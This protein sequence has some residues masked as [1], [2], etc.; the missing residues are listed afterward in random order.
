LDTFFPGHYSFD[1]RLLFN[2]P[3]VKLEA[4]A[5]ATIPTPG[6]PSGSYRGGLLFYA[7]E[8]NVEFL[9]QIGMPRFAPSIDTISINLFSLLFEPRVNLG[10]LHIIPTFFWHPQ[11]YL[12]VET[13]ELGS[14]DVNLNFLFQGEANPQ[15][16][17]GIEANL[18]FSNDEVTG[19]QELGVKVSPYASLATPGVL[20]D[21]KVNANVFPFDLGS[22]IDVFLGI[23]AVF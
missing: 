18:V 20:W 13:G 19:G 14:F 10:I 12:Q 4:F 5:G 3:S 1:A 7:G 21:L 15:I 11:Y 6:A 17:G 9:A 23:R 22:L 8:S 16:N 2:L